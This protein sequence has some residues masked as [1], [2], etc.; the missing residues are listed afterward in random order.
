M[1]DEKAR[2]RMRNLTVEMLHKI[3][4]QA[5]MLENVTGMKPVLFMSRRTARLFAAGW[6]LEYKKVEPDGVERIRIEGYDV[7]ICDVEDGVYVGYRI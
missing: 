1:N 4:M 6:P 7:T 5:E 2:E 3:L